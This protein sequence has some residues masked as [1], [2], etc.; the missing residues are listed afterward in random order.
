MTKTALFISMLG[1]RVH[2]RPEEYRSLC[3]TGLEKDWILKWHGGSAA[4]AGLTLSS[5]DICR[6]DRLPEVNDIDRVVL[7]G[8][9]HVVCL[10]YTSPSPRDS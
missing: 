2:F 6:G 1:E 7:G 9:M 5:V 3:P 4:N 8:T 10:L